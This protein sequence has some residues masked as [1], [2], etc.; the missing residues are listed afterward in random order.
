MR[1]TIIRIHNF[2][3][4]LVK[5]ENW[6]SFT[7][8]LR[9][10]VQRWGTDQCSSQLLRTCK[11]FML[12]WSNT[13]CLRKTIFYAAG[14]VWGL[15]FWGWTIFFLNKNWYFSLW[16]SRSWN[17][18]QQE[19][20]RY[21]QKQPARKEV[22]Q[23]GFM[24]RVIWRSYLIQTRQIPLQMALLLP[25]W[26]SRAKWLELDGSLC[27]V[28]SKLRLF[29]TFGFSCQETRMLSPSWRQS[30]RQNYGQP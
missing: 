3:C 22:E 1:N 15:T 13:S 30:M 21:S 24:V 26:V 10:G 20:L 5:Y 27:P 16:L 4:F 18:H 7:H 19:I 6:R 28:S 17:K 8:P 25:S 14:I 11:A 29:S 9:C 2:S 12:A 23:G